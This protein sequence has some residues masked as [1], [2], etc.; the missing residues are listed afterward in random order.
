MAILVTNNASA[1]IALSITSSATS[2]ILAAGQGVEFPSPGPSDYFYATLV[3]SSNNLEI[4]KCTSRSTDT[5][6]VVR[7]QDNTSARSFA[8]G[9]LIELRVVAA[10]FVDLQTE[11][12]DV[13]AQIVP[14]FSTGTVMLFAQ[15]AAPTGW[16][17]ITTQ[18]NKAL[19]VVSGTGGGSGGSVSFTSAFSN[20]NV[21]D[22]ALSAAQIP[23]HAH[24]FSGTSSSVS[25]DH[26]HGFSGTT[27]AVG[28][29]AHSYTVTGGSGSINNASIEGG[30]ATFGTSTGGAG[31][32]SH[33]YSGN[34][35]GISA[36]HTHS[37]SGTTSSIGSGTA[38]TH[39]LNLDVQYVDIILAS[40]D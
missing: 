40:K 15:A 35:G 39:T 25:N 18:N 9:S 24:T 37:Y 6:T 13:Q 30:L 32:H 8:A 3:D 34:T 38:H 20:Q 23:G 14:A 10:T 33:T 12:A 26:T 17:K 2:I 16:T 21:G 22:T 36:N 4:V 27:A 11:I 7:G 19:R 1:E 31:A 28:D 29:H 5:L